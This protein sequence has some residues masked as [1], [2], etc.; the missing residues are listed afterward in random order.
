MSQSRGQVVAIVLA[1]GASRR[2]G[3]NKMLLPL[4]KE[5]LVRRTVRR[6]LEAGFD[7]VWVVLGRDAESV[8]A[9]LEG[10]PV[11]T[12]ENPRYP[13]GLGTSFRA[14]VEALPERVEA[15]VFVLADQVFVTPEM[16]RK[17][18]EA[19]RVSRAKVVLSHFGQV[20]APPH[21]FRR[22]L[23]PELGQ[24]PDRGAKEV[25]ERYRS[26]TLTVELPGSALFD[27]DT[28]DDYQE[29]LRRLADE[30]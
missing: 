3:E 17:V 4:G 27:L 15:A 16:Y 9:Q 30:P 29:A 13:E 6:V 7:A 8:R 21:L 23:F 28:P 11:Q 22:E 1:A 20:Q 10:L 12:V 25:I 14:A 18:L 2:M 26:E 19:Y 24:R 5:S